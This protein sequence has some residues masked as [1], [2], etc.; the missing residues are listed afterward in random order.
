MTHWFI[1]R[2]FLKKI[3][4]ICGGYIF[5]ALGAIGSFVPLLPTTPFLLLAVFC[6]SKSSK[7]F[8]NWIEN[9]KLYQKHLK[10][11]VEQKGMPLK[12]KLWIQLLASTMML[13]S[14]FLIDSIHARILLIVGILVHNYVFIFR[15]KTIK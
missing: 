10:D 3:I 6:F 12:Q 14:F 4:Y 2:K 11:Y 9:T 7:R 13:I 8:Q 1:R 5:F 15:I